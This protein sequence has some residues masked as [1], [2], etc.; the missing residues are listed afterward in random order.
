[1]IKVRSSCN[2]GWI[3]DGTEDVCFDQRVVEFCAAAETHSSQVQPEGL[4]ISSMLG[5][6]KVLFIRRR[7]RNVYYVAS[8]LQIRSNGPRHRLVW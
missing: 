5:L 3:S 4:D 6:H 1:M 8:T 7:Y 2:D